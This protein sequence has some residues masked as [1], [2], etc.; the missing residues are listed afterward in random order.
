MNTIKHSVTVFLVLAW[1]CVVK[2]QVTRG[3]LDPFSAYLNCSFDD[4]LKLT[5]KVRLPKK[6]EKYR[7]LAVADG[8]KKRVSRLDGYTLEYS[9]PRTNVFVN[10]KVE[11]SS[12]QDYENDKKII[13]ESLSHL[14]STS[15]YVDDKELKRSNINGIDVYSYERNTLDFGVTTALSLFFED[16]SRKVVTIYFL[17]HKPDKRKA[18]T[19]DEFRSLRDKFL[20]KFTRCVSGN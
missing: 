18:Q 1:C 5:E 20:D 9:Y 7:D 10:L 17:N 6:A 13:F 19:L 12:E 11:Q 3:P 15:K 16:K 2:G 14:L 8:V 4:E